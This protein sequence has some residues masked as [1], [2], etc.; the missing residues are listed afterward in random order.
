MLVKDHYIQTG[1]SWLR[2]HKHG[3]TID[4]RKVF[5]VAMPVG[6]HRSNIGFSW[7]AD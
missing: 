2:I 4:F 7:V 5:G 3:D 1:F 6:E